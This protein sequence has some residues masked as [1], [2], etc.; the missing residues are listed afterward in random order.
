MKVLTICIPCH[1]NLQEMHKAIGSCLLMIDDIQLLLVDENSDD[2]TYDVL[3]EYQNEY[4]NDI[5][6][7]KLDHEN[8]SYLDIRDSIDGLY[9]KLLRATSYFK[10][11]SLVTLVE[12]LQDFIRVQ[13][14][15]D[16]VINDYQIERETKKPLKYSFDKI[17]KTEKLLGWH[18]KGVSTIFNYKAI[19][20]KTSI[21]KKAFD[22]YP[23]LGNYLFDSIGYNGLEEI[24]SLYYLE[25]VLYTQADKHKHPKDYYVLAS[26]LIATYHAD[27]L[28]SHNKRI[29]SRKYLTSYALKALVQLLDHDD[30]CRAE[31][32]LQQISLQPKLAKRLNKE[33]YGNVMSVNKLISVNKNKLL[34][35]KVEKIDF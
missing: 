16:L 15:L 24:N 12:T 25:E 14:N 3:L 6:V 18:S 17:L 10:K 2:S 22:T 28:K 4:P 11:G 31:D 32:L 7:I 21:F 5:K 27:S 35:K 8:M 33:M 1:N 26:A 30:Y 19:T 9:F 29:Y 34:R 20:I 23:N 13:A